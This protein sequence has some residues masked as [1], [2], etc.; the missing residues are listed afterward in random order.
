MLLIRWRDGGRAV[1][2]AGLAYDKQKTAWK[3]EF[4]V[5]GQEQ[6]TSEVTNQ[7]R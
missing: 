6:Y 4:T 1:G 7:S 2:K 3:N 5:Y